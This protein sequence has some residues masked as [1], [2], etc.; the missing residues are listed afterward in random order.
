MTP[1]G[2][3]TRLGQQYDPWGEFFHGNVDEL[4]IFSGALTATEVARLA[5][6]RPREPSLTIQVAQVRLCWVAQPEVMYQLQYRS[7]LTTNLWTDLGSPIRGNGETNCV[8]QD[9]GSPCRHYR[10]VALP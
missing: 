6:L 5:A 1:D 8:T 4:W 10:V 9:V 2:A 7:E 3:D